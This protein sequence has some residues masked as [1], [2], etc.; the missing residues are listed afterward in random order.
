MPHSHSSLH[1]LP[2][3][4]PQRRSSPP[5]NQASTKPNFRSNKSPIPRLMLSPLNIPHPSTASRNPI[6]P[7]RLHQL[8]QSPA[9]LS[10]RSQMYNTPTRND[11]EL[12]QQRPSMCGPW[13]SHQRNSR[14]ALACHSHG[15]GLFYRLAGATFSVT[16][17]AL[18]VADQLDPAADHC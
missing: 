12:P 11:M 8:A 6:S 1:R 16:D 17:R 18:P 7:R 15:K 14:I 13:R 10:G 5:R 3:N 9:S 2:H 4:L